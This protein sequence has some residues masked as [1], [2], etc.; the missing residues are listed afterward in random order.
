MAIWEIISNFTWILLDMAQGYLYHVWCGSS[1]HL[2]QLNHDVI[3]ARESSK[4]R[5][6]SEVEDGEER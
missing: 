2:G 1:L 5:R 4:P 6:E 3:P